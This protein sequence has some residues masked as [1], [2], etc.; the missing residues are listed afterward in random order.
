V[1]VI[2]L[3]TTE[4]PGFWS[5]ESGVPVPI[6]ARDERDAAAIVGQHASRGLGSGV[7]VSVPIPEADALPH[8]ESEAAIAQA[9]DEAETAGRSGP[10]TTPW[11]LARIAELTEGRSLAANA[12]LIVHNAAVGARLAIALAALEQSAAPSRGRDD[13]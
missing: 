4:L 10:D 13:R 6:T 3:G 9:L 5:R 7:L 12:A 2:G 8:A 11:L 1:P